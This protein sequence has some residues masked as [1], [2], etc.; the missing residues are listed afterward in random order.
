MKKENVF[1]LVLV[2]AL[3]A[4]CVYEFATGDIVGGIVSLLYVVV[5]FFS[6]GLIRRNRELHE[7]NDVLCEKLDSLMSSSS[8]VI[9]DGDVIDFG[10]E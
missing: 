3:L 5:L 4:S 7:L 10:D 8:A 6:F 1:C 2:I 9:G